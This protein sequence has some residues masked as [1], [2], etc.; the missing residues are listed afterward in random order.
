MA[1]VIHRLYRFPSLLWQS[2][3]CLLHTR[4]KTSLTAV[5]YVAIRIY[6][7]SRLCILTHKLVILDF[8]VSKCL[9]FLESY[10]S[11][12]TVTISTTYNC[13]DKITVTED[14]LVVHLTLYESLYLVCLL[15]FVCRLWS[16]GYIC[17]TFLNNISGIMPVLFNS[18]LQIW[19]NNSTLHRQF[20]YYPNIINISLTCAGRL[21][22]RKHQ[23]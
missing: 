9:Y 19:Q 20:Q 13:I 23:K 21:V 7:E 11:C 1:L 18:S 6:W 10:T 14:T 12:L 8:S 4:S 5:L 3:A 22:H 15:Y 2:G 16:I 17:I